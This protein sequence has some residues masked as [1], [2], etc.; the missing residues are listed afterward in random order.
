[1]T[2]FAPH[3]ST[4]ASYL[5]LTLI[6]P[7][8]G[9]LT[10][11]N[12]KRNKDVFIAI[13]IFVAILLTGKRAHSIF[14][15][16]AIILTYFIINPNL[17]FKKW[18]KL[19]G[20]IIAGIVMLLIL[21]RFVPQI[22]NVVNRFIDSAEKG[23]IELGR[24]VQRALA[25]FLWTKSPIF[26]IGWDA[27]KYTFLDLTGNL[28]NVHNVYIQLLCEVGIVGCIPFAIFFIT[29]IVNGIRVAR[30]VY[31]NCEDNG[32]TMRKIVFALYEQLF[33]LIYCFTGNP[34]YDEPTL[35]MYLSGC[36]VS[37]YYFYKL[38]KGA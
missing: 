17:D 25:L 18:A 19:L 11:P 29:S 32:T 9:I 5:A 10:N 8:M 13:M 22:L 26:G 20:V 30:Y 24:G 6:V 7:L 4:N 36:A 21:S 14:S 15:L 33:F 27:Y 28:I 2:G 34:L 23:D 35:F 3:Y 31:F 37:D 1:M 38:I 12:Q 16:I